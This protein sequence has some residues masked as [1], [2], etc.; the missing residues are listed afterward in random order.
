MTHLVDQE[1]GIQIDYSNPNEHI[2]E[3]ERSIQVKK[4]RIYYLIDYQR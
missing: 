2:P 1:P 3:I 4:E